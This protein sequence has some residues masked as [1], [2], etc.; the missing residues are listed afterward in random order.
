[1]QRVHIGYPFLQEAKVVK[2]S[3]ELFDYVV[4]PGAENTPHQIRAIEHSGKGIDDFH[5]KTERIEKYYSKRLG[6]LIG[7]IE[8]LV[9]VEMLKGLKKL[10]DGSTVKEFV[11]MPGLDMIHATQVVVENVTSEDVR[12][13]EQAALPIE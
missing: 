8:S 3:D 13:I 10:D 2:V 6:M 11:E 5:K 9:Q 12:F 1:N 7:D 4:Y